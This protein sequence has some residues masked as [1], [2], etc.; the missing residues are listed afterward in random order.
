METISLGTGKTGVTTKKKLTQKVIKAFAHE[1]A[2]KC[3]AISEAQIIA[4]NQVL[5]KPP[6]LFRE[7]NEPE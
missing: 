5:L 2:T 1:V 6:G 4:Q 3:M 7:K